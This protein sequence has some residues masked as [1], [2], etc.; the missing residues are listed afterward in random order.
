[1]PDAADGGD[2]GQPS[3]APR[4]VLVTGGS[5][6]IGLAV[7]RRFQALGDHVAVTYNS[8]PPPDGLFGVQCDVTDGAQVDAAFTTIEERFGHAVEVLV[9]TDRNLPDDPAE[10]L[11]GLISVS[12]PAGAAVPTL[13]AEVGRVGQDNEEPT[14][15]FVG[16]VRGDGRLRD[17]VSTVDNAETLLGWIAAVFGLEAGRD[18]SV[19]HY[20]FREGADEA[21]PERRP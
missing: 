20:G 13:V 4:V 8:S 14:P 16:S 6:G 15:S 11:A 5:R 9:L 2:D 18:G 19:G 10:M 3:P 12:D 21:I 17:E 1:M 7:A